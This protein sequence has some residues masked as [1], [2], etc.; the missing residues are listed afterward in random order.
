M[1]DFHIA[2]HKTI[3]I[4]GKFHNTLMTSCLP[5]NWAIWV[6]CRAHRLFPPKFA[7]YL[8]EFNNSN[9]ST[10]AKTDINKS[11]LINF[12]GRTF[13]Q[14]CSRNLLEAR[15]AK[16]FQLD[17]QTRLAWFA[18]WKRQ[19]GFFWSINKIS[20][21]LWHFKITVFL[22]SAR[23]AIMRRCIFLKLNAVVNIGQNFPKIHRCKWNVIFTFFFFWKF[24][25]SKPLVR[26]FKSKQ[27]RK[28]C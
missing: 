2:L 23:I 25:R 15:K 14:C 24:D 4:V 8:Y 28:H 3:F 13:S 7:L 5:K 17:C 18:E 10:S 27:A 19:S 9:L 12:L 20:G 21:V 22:Q 26:E 16:K 11:E 1:P 6:E